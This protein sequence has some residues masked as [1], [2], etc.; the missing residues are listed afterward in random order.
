MEGEFDPVDYIPCSEKDPAKLLE[1]L[2]V[3]IKNIENKYIKAL[4]EEIF[5]K[6]EYI[7]KRFISHSAAKSI[8]HSYMGGL[9]EHTLSVVEICDFMSERYKYV[10]KDLLYSYSYAA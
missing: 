1:K 4:L 9:V 2:S 6:N 8:H 5:Y 3:Y 10:N 7:K